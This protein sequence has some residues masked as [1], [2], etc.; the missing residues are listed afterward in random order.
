MVIDLYEPYFLFFGDLR[1]AIDP[2]KIR[3]KNWQEVEKKEPFNSIKKALQTRFI[4][5][6]HQ[7]HG[8]KGRVITEEQ[9][10]LPLFLHEGDYLITTQKGIGL[11]VATADCL[12]VVIISKSFP[13]AAVIH[14]GWRGL[15]A[16]IVTDVIDRFYKEYQVP[17]TDIK[18]I[19]G[20]AAQV[21]C[22]EV[23]QDFLEL[24]KDRVDVLNAC[25]KDAGKLFFDAQLFLLNVCRQKGLSDKSLDFSFHVC[26]ICEQIYCSYRREKKSPLRQLTVVSLK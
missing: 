14:A 5:F 8:V 22:Y 6:S 16:G 2:A 25:K 26:T 12:P 10:T 4:A 11:A 20:P 13:V 9:Q 23:G 24:H 18:L 3:G 19:V 15:V 1:T 21:C 7:V 17:L